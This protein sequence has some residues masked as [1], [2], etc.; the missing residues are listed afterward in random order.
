MIPGSVDINSVWN[1]LPPGIHD[2][3]LPEIKQRFAT[4]EKRR[5]LFAGFV[6][7][8]KALQS[9]GCKT[10]YLDGSY[11]TDK[12]KPG[13]F[14]ACWDPSGVDPNKLDPVLLDFSDTRRKQKERF[15][16]E[17]FPSRAMA[18]GTSLFVDFFQ[19]DKHTGKA[20]GIVRVR[21]P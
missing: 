8:I 1:V 2:A 16:G 19:I 21:L 12:P 6:D 9:A 3:T 14:D 20:K 18:D 7:G 4:S 17:F 11:V 5:E 13:D 15:G 10:V